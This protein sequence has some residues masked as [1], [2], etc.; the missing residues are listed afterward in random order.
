MEQDAKPYKTSD[1]PLAAYLFSKGMTILGTVHSK[2]DGK[3]KY[4][5]F[6]DHPQR[7]EWVEEF[8]SGNDQVSAGYYFKA[9]REVRRYLYEDNN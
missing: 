9:T 1:L 6:V 8:V 5:V 2:T 4:F 3:R 7:D